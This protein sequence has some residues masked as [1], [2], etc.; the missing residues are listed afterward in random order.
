MNILHITHYSH[1]ILLVPGCLTWEQYDT[2]SNKVFVIT[3]IQDEQTSN[4]KQ[5][6]KYDLNI[7]THGMKHNT[8]CHI[9]I[10]DICV[11]YD[12]KLWENNKGLK[13]EINKWHQRSEK[14]HNYDKSVVMRYGNTKNF[15][16]TFHEL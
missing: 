7:S 16:V 3:D 10:L 1:E 5:K 2:Q 11:Y 13:N 14:S 9:C 4:T 6:I 12:G 15:I 8:S